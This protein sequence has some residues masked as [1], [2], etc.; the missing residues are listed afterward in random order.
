MTDKEF[1]RAVVEKIKHEYEVLETNV[2]PADRGA[3]AYQNAKSRVIREM[4][5]EHPDNKLDNQT[6]SDAGL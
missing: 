1:N 5:R 3:G 6:L 2:D 4:Q